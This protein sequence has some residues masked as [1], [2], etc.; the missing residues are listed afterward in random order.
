MKKGKPKLRTLSLDQAVNLLNCGGLIAYPTET[1]YGLAVRADDGPAIQKIFAVKKREHGKPISILIPNQ[2][3]LES[4]AK[5][6][7]QR[8][9]ML[10]KHFWPGPLTLVFCARKSVARALTAGTGKIGIRISS[11]KTAQALGT[12]L[13]GAITTTSANL[14]G[15][16]ACLTAAAVERQFGK[17][18]DGIVGRSR[19]KSSKGS[20][21]LDVSG[22]E[23]RLLREGEVTMQAIQ[24]VLK[25]RISNIR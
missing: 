1:F 9:R 20:T 12:K 7:K 17:K 6:I 21:V 2:K 15:S 22:R 24:K 18:I 14:S 19:L 3:H 23:V 4:W 5:N 16:F 11:H 25:L 8:D 10:I 13:A